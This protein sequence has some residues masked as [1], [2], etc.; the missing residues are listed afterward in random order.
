MCEPS[1]FFVYANDTP[2]IFFI[3]FTCD[4][5]HTRLTDKPT[6]IAGRIP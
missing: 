4:A 2:A 6:F 5:E 1:D 3:A